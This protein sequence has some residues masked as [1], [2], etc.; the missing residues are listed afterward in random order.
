M[1]DDQPFLARRR[2]R[3]APGDDLSVRA[4]DPDRQHLHRDIAVGRIRRLDLDEAERVGPSGDDADG[5]DGDLLR[6]A[7]RGTVRSSYDRSGPRA[8]RPSSTSSG[9]P[10]GPGAG[11][12]DRA[13]AMRGQRAGP[14]ARPS[15]RTVEAPRSIFPEVPAPRPHM[16]GPA[17][18]R[19]T[20][21]VAGVRATTTSTN[22]RNAM[23]MRTRNPLRCLDLP[24]IGGSS[25]WL[26]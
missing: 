17:T 16:F 26:R 19:S 15:E 25:R 22:R 8:R 10:G 20:L 7:D 1:A 3:V 21:T 23:T 2:D 13:G 4:A 9:W 18:R 5:A 24:R 14:A 11:R 6:D 12:D